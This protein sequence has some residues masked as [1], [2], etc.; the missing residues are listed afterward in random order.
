MKRRGIEW[1]ALDKKQTKAIV[2][3]DHGPQTFFA[4][5]TKDNI[6]KNKARILDELTKE[7]AKIEKEMKRERI[8]KLKK[9]VSNNMKQN[10]G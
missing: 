8:Y 9:F 3:S 6:E 7:Y 5:T 2:C 4:G 10:G 1:G